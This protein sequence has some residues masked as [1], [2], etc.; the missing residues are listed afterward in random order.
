MDPRAIHEIKDEKA[1]LQF[2][3]DQMENFMKQL[4]I[5]KNIDPWRQVIGVAVIVLVQ[6]GVVLAKRFYVYVNDFLGEV[7]ETD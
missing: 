2:Q 7:G 5:E 1:R 4:N 3:I 6:Y